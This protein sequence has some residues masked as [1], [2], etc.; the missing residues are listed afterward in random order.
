MAT[1]NVASP[2]SHQLRYWL[3][4]IRGSDCPGPLFRPVVVLDDVD[5]VGALVAGGEAVEDVRVDG[6]EGG[7]GPWGHAVVECL[8]DLALKVG[9]GV[10]G[11]D[12]GAVGVTDVVVA[13]AEDVVFG[14]GGDE[15]DFGFHELGDGWGR[16]QGDGGPD[17]ADAVFGDGVAAQEVAG[18][19]GAADL[20][21]A[22][23][24]AVFGV[25][26]EVVEHGADV[27]KLGVVAEVAVAALEAAPEEH[28]AGVVV[29]EVAGA[30]P[31]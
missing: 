7:V 4:G 27:E 26:A 8:Q 1:S 14:A 2:A 11:G 20:E 21:A 22:A 23:G 15:G 12:G 18:L 19:V 31:D 10:Q 3:A 17:A 9:A 24:V 16:V 6:A 29:D 28:P 5:E 30:V 25:E 13:D